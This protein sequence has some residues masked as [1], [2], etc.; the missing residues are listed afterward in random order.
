MLDN[1][2]E[3]DF[4]H[5]KSS[6]RNGV[7]G[8]DLKRRGGLYLLEGEVKD[9]R[10]TT[11]MTEV[12]VMP[13]EGIP[14]S[15]L[16]ED[17][18]EEM[19]KAEPKELAMPTLPEADVIRRHEMTHAIAE[20]WCP[21]CVKARGRDDPHHAREDEEKH[22]QAV[23]ELPIVQMDYTLI[24]GV[25]ILDM[26]VNTIR[27]GAGTVVEKKEITKFAVQWTLKKF[28]QFGLVDVKI[29]T[30]P[31]HSIVAVVQE[32]RKLRTQKTLVEATPEAD[33]QAIG[34]V[35]RFHRTMQD[36]L[37]ALKLQVEL[38]LE[39]SLK[40]DMATT[41]WLVR[42]A[43]WIIQVRGEHIIQEYGVFSST[44]QELQRYDGEFVRD[45]V[46]AQSGR[47]T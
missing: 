2:W 15:T 11:E 12:L 42:H 14:Q 36:Q 4:G 3:V 46:G 26:Y 19:T 38:N 25:T 9:A 22:T 18:I 41:K 31:E 32:I 28:E 17:A 34:G 44:Q 24:D 47:C 43:S 6:I 35:E 10:L 27:C 40:A 20:S 37:R 8:V 33:H 23:D 45:G 5:G 7:N 13:V 21:T 30:D 1:G 16:M 29:R 39:I